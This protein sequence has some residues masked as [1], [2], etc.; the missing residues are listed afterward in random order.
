MV[1]WDSLAA[2]LAEG[3]MQLWVYFLSPGKAIQE[4]EP[5]RTVPV[6]RKDPSFGP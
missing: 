5:S 4:E 1:L 2:L 3:S 6:C